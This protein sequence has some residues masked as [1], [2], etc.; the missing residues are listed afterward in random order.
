MQRKIN[1]IVLRGK[2]SAVWSEIGR[3]NGNVQTR[4][5]E[6]L[7]GVDIMIGAGFHVASTLVAALTPE[8]SRIMRELVSVLS[9]SHCDF[10]VPDITAWAYEAAEI[11]KV[12]SAKGT[13]GP[14][15]AELA[16]SSVAIDD[17]Y[18]YTHDLVLSEPIITKKSLPAALAALKHA[19]VIVDSCACV[20]VIKKRVVRCLETENDFY[21]NYIAQNPTA[22]VAK[23]TGFGPECA[24]MARKLVPTIA[25]GTIKMLRNGQ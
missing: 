2:E 9:Y 15:L 7:F 6:R 11:V 24:E 12:I 18:Y 21:N 8:E 5:V 23:C 14:L 19:Y 20:R 1:E 3:L 16:T 13:T 10:S 25:A 22:K 4:A 17:V